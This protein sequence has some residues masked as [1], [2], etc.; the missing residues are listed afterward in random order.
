MQESDTNLILISVLKSA[1]TRN[2]IQN[3][4]DALNKLDAFIL[5]K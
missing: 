4:K 3:R 2:I 1:V 5:W